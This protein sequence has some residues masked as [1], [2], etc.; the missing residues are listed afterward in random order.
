MWDTTCCWWNSKKLL[1]S[2]REYKHI[3]FNFIFCQRMHPTLLSVIFQGIFL[4]EN[5]K[6]TCHFHFIQSQQWFPLQ[7]YSKWHENCNVANQDRCYSYHWCVTGSLGRN[8]FISILLIRETLTVPWEWILTFP[9][10]SHN[11]LHFLNLLNF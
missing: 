2:S 7:K 10:L 11:L 5:G 1:M 8:I 6:I 4:W 9:C 3:N